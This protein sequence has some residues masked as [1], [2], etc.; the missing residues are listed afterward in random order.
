MS[1]KI[2]IGKIIKKT[3][4]SLH[5]DVYL[6]MYTNSADVFLCGGASQ[7]SIRNKVRHLLTVEKNIRIMYPEDI[8]IEILN[9]DRDSNLLTLEKFLAE[10]CDIICIICESPGSLVELGAFTNNVNTED[11]VIA[12][13]EKSREKKKSFIM[14]GPVKL[15]KKKNKSNVIIYDNNK[16][17][18]LAK[19]IKSTIKVKLKTKNPKKP[20][21]SIIGLYYFIPMLLYFFN[22]LDS[23]H[24]VGYIKYIFKQKKYTSDDF[25]TLF[26]SSLKLLYKDKTIEKTSNKY[27]LTEN[28]YNS[29]NQTLDGVAIRNKSKLYDYLRFGIIY[30]K[31]NNKNTA[32]L[33]VTLGI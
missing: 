20:L 7:N 4:I 6:K 29:I 10:N 26:R 12:I 13:I 16:L 11:K 21:N 25:D 32:S 1:N 24:L 3:L 15:L 5:D 27:S 22:Y 30:N 23:Y 33:D 14:L 8:F 17:D 28:G 18:I 31:Y 9:K 19:N 2:T